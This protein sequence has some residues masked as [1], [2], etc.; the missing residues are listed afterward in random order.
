MKPILILAGTCMLMSGCRVASIGSYTMTERPRENCFYEIQIAGSS[1]REMEPIVETGSELAWTGE[2]WITVDQ[3][4]VVVGYAVRN[5]ALRSFQY[6][7]EEGLNAGGST[8]KCGTV[9]VTRLHYFSKK[10]YSP[11][12]AV[13][14]LFIPNLFGVPVRS[15]KV[16]NSYLFEV[17]D[18]AGDLIYRNVHSGTGKA[19]MGL[20]YGW[21]NTPEKAEYEATYAAVEDFLKGFYSR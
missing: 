10:D 17:Y 7:L 12:M 8:S 9:R 18:V 4:D 21:K 1:F 5:G 2:E 20:Y 13:I 16:D 14:T 6:F 19:K 11:G 15:N 3:P